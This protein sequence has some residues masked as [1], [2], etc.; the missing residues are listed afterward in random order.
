MKFDVIIG[1]PPYQA[2]GGTQ[3]GRTI[4]DKIVDVSL[5]HVKD[6]GYMTFV[7]PGR[8]RQ[9]EDK[10]R[11]MYT[12]NQLVYLSIHTVKDGMKTFGACT[13]YDVYMIKKRTPDRMARIRFSDGTE[14]QY[15]A[16]RWPFIPNAMIDFW[17]KAFETKGPYLKVWQSGSHSPDKKHAQKDIDSEHPHTFIHKMSDKGIEMWHSSRPHKHQGVPKFAFRD[18]G[19]P[20]ACWCVDGC[21][22]HTYYILGADL[23]IM[24]WLNH[25]SYRDIAASV[26]FGH[27]Q[28]P[29]KPLCY[30]PLSLIDVEPQESERKAELC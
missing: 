6:D 28:V 24:K 23:N 30:L 1:N 8:W 9:P 18:Q 4:W 2:A 12:T 29:Y 15:L 5:D 11:K 17:I 21:G 7:H 22:T 10:L 16:Q 27:R 14:G 13:P 25:G 26:T 19:K 20:H 3:T